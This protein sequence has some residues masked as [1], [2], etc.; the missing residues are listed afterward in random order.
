MIRIGQGFD[1]HNLR[2]ETVNYRWY[3]RFLM[4]KDYRSFGCGCIVA[5]DC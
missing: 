1:V 2:K 4:K 5:Y 3:Y